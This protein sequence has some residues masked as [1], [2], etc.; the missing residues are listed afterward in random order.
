MM[1]IKSVLL[2]L[3]FMLYSSV[4]AFAG[5]LTVAVAANVQYAFDELKAEFQKETGINVKPVI[6]SSG[7][8]TTQIENGAP[9][10]VFLSADL[11][12]PQALKKAGL[13]INDPKIYAYG[14]LVLWTLDHIDLSKGMDVLLA[15][16]VKKIAVASPEA[17]PYGR[18]AINV[19]QHY[20]LYTKVQDKLVYGESIAQANQF[21]TSKAAE[22]GF[23]AKSVV[24]APTMKDQGKWI[25]VPQE[26]Y[27]LIAQGVVILKY[28]EKGSLASAQKFFDFLFTEKA[29][30]IFKKYGY[31]L[32]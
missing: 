10:D 30:E 13:T 8:F 31:I 12:Y 29:G 6:G 24:L 19:L 1:K 25:D 18:Q 26:A 11:K 32:P 20:N 28:T 21:I 16:E 14:S 22:I 27:E 4:C 5:D 7:K 17:A 23:T 15:P 3:L 9:F 2:L